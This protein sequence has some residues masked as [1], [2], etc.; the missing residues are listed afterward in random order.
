MVTRWLTVAALV[1]IVALPARAQGALDLPED[2]WAADPALADLMNW[3]TF[4]M[5]FDAG[6]IV[7]DMAAGEWE[8][9]LRGEAQFAP[10]RDGLALVCGPGSVR[11]T[12]PRGPNATMGTRGACSLWVCPVEWTRENGGNT[13]FVTASN[14]AF[15]LQR[16]GPAH[17]EEGRYT[18][19]EGMQYLIRGDLTGNQILMTGTANWPNGKWRLIVANWSWPVMSWSIDGGELQST[20]VDN[21]PDDSYFGGIVVGA[22]GGEPT[23]IDDLTFYRRPLSIAEIRLIHETF[24][25]EHVTPTEEQP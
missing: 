25:P 15:Y 13:T 19:H 5:T 18:R 11:A 10:G 8:A 20:A 14:G 22:E 17:N 6:G 24:R 9:T 3:V 4:Q 21:I 12:F 16:Q 1:T 2:P 7:P 23:L